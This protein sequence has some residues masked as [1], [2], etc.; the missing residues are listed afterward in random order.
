[1]ANPAIG[2][3]HPKGAAI[4]MKGEHRKHK[5]VAGRTMTPGASM[6]PGSKAPAPAVVSAA[7]HGA[8]PPPSAPAPLGSGGKFG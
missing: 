3:Y 5:A 7:V 4:G 1:M 6:I 2:G 8:A